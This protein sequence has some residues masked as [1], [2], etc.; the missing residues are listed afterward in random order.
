MRAENFQI[1]RSQTKIMLHLDYG[2]AAGHS[3]NDMLA[4]IVP[5]GGVYEIPNVEEYRTYL[6]SHNVD[7]VGME[8]LFQLKGCSRSYWRMFDPQAGGFDTD[9]A[10]IRSGL[11]YA[12]YKAG[13]TG[14]VAIA[15]NID[16]SILA[17]EQRLGDVW[18]SYFEQLHYAVAENLHVGVR[19]IG[20]GTINL[21]LNIHSFLVEAA[22]LRD[23]LASFLALKVFDGAKKKAKGSKEKSIKKMSELYE[24]LKHTPHEED[25]AQEIIQID[26]RENAGGWLARLN[27]FRNHLVH[28]GPISE[29]GRKKEVVFTTHKIASLDVPIVQYDLPIDP[30]LSPEGPYIDAMKQCVF[31]ARKMLGL[32]RDVVVASG[33]KPEIMCFEAANSCIKAG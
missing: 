23:H 26:D 2:L 16:F 9:V 32:V 8:T 5:G 13:E 19:F 33:V 7:V 28:D 20:P 21:F 24:Y 1:R 18:K 29:M 31:L 15:E 6:N 11:V 12:L 30:I 27:E 25:I 4:I 3:E 22:T 10:T 14:S 17:M